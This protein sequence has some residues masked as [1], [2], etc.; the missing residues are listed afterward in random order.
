MGPTCAAL[1]S[2]DLSSVTKFSQSLFNFQEWNNYGIILFRYGICGIIFFMIWNNLTQKNLA[3]LA[4][5]TLATWRD[6]SAWRG[7]MGSVR[8][9]RGNTPH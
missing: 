2:Q 8:V 5:A 1:T 6:Y 7:R 9:W 3:T 4:L